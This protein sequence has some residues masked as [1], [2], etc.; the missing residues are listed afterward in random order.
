MKTKTLK[1]IRNELGMTQ[2]EMAEALNTPYSTYQ[3]WELGINKKVPGIY[4][5]AIKTVKYLALTQLSDI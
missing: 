1:Q 5:V 3:K 4:W 2:E